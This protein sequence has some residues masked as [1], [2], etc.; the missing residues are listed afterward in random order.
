[1]RLS[2]T[3]KLPQLQN[4]IKRDPGGYNDEFLQQ[5]RHYLSE[6]QIFRLDP[7]KKSTSFSELVTFVSHVAPCYPAHCKDFPGQLMALLRQ[8]G[9]V[10]NPDVRITVAH[11]LLLLRNRGLLEALP[12]F[13]LM[14]ELFEIQDKALKALVY[15]HMTADVRKVMIP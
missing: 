1:M 6:L 4:L 3:T 13:T 8:H 9:R 7:S 15:N 14:F 11:A 5:H 12:L 10:L 2:V